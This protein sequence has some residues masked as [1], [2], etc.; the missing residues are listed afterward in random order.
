[1]LSEVQYA[2]PMKQILCGSLQSKLSG[3]ELLKLLIKYL[4]V[5][6]VW[7]IMILC[8]R[9]KKKHCGVAFFPPDKW[10]AH[11]WLDKNQNAC[12]IL[13]VHWKKAVWIGAS[14]VFFS[15]LS[16]ISPNFKTKNKTD[17]TEDNW[18]SF[19]KV[20][21]YVCIIEHAELSSKWQIHHTQQV[22]HANRVLVNSCLLSWMSFQHIC[23]FPHNS[24]APPPCPC[25]FIFSWSCIALGS[26][27]DLLELSSQLRKKLWVP[28]LIFKLPQHLLPEQLAGQ[29]KHISFCSTHQDIS[30]SKNLS[31]FCLT[32]NF[33]IS[34]E[35]LHLWEHCFTGEYEA[36]S[37]KARLRRR[38]WESINKQITNIP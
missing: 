38:T 35:V 11:L 36:K 19:Q 14:A 2:Q 8:T 26:P 29:A 13:I 17:N 16:I 15:I 25:S 31:F 30:A 18:L 32:A 10:K 22:V 23:P 5:S 27:T 21:M 24:S 1:M 9:E 33:Y 6:G 28:W 34:V 7:S 37:Q 20:A 4:E 12:H 3:Q